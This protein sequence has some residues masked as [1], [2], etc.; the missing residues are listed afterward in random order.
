MPQPYQ[1]IYN[2]NGGLNNSTSD[3]AIDVSELSD[4]SNYIPD[5]LSGGKVIKR[6]GLTQ[7]STGLSSATFTSVFCGVAGNYFTAGVKIYDF[8]GAELETLS[9]NNPVSWCS[10]AGYDLMVNGTDALQTVDGST[11]AS[12]SGIPAGVKYLASANNFVYYAGHQHGMLAWSTP[13]SITS[14][15]LVNALVLTA[16]ENDDIIG[17]GN[18]VN[19]VF[20]ALNRSFE[21]VSGSAELGQGVSYYS[22]GTGCTSNPSILTTPD[23]LFWWSISGIVWLKFDFSL[24]LPMIRKIPA[25]LA[26]LNP[27]EFG[28]VHGCFDPYQRRVSFWVCNGTSQTTPN[29][30][31]DYY[32]A[33]DTFWTHQSGLAT[34]MTASGKA[35]VASVTANYCGGIGAGP[36]YKMAGDTDAGTPIDSYLET[37][38]DSGANDRG[39]IG[40]TVY[41]LGRKLTVQTNLN[42]AEDIIYS[43]YVDSDSSIESDNVWTFQPSPGPQDTILGLNR[44]HRKIKHRLEDSAPTRTR[45]TSMVMDAIQ[46]RTV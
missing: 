39:A 7:Q 37:K 20:V 21:M 29:M 17:L 38:R 45:I 30:R 34:Q 8:T 14:W 25:T 2:L 26:G 10:F 35:A 28:I 6:E 23:G 31:I 36:L 11:F 5:L 42:T 46:I 32:Y 44:Q 27:A 9:N 41:K 13:G 4:C 22:K 19:A 15:P 12:I 3:E 33:L 43:C 40:A 1:S 16:D 24:D 18:A